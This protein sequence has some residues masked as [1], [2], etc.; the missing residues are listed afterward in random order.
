MKLLTLVRHA[1]SSWQDQDSSDHDR[2][3]NARGL[4]DAP[5]M[6]QR[7]QQHGPLP[8]R[9]LCSS[10]KRTR[11]TCDIFLSVWNMQQDAATYDKALYLAATGT[12]QSL[13][14]HTPDDVDHL[15]LIAHNPGLERL[16]QI[17]HPD[18]P[19]ALPTCATVQFELDQASF[20]LDNAEAINL[21]RYDFPKNPG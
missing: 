16:G 5:H 12:I 4:N 17:L 10:A 3:L 20:A 15:M 18:A 9:I 8:D 13:I 6:A 11:E 21:I 19:K 2:T 14:E 7:L 1:K